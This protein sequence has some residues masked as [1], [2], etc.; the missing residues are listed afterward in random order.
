M[1]RGFA[2]LLRE[3]RHPPE[4]LPASRVAEAIARAYRRMPR[5]DFSRDLPLA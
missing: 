5:A 2:G 3:L 4:E 1:M